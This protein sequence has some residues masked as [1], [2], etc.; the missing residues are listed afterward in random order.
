MPL[1]MSS[2]HRIPCNVDA[3]SCVGLEDGLHPNPQRKDSPYFIMCYKGFLTYTG[4]CPIDKHNLQLFPKNGKCRQNIKTLHCGSNPTAIVAH[5]KRCELYYNC[6][7]RHTNIPSYIK[8]YG[9]GP[10]HLKPYLHTCTYPFQFDSDLKICRN[11]TEVQCEH[12][13]V[14]KDA[15][16]YIYS[17]PLPMSSSHRIPCNVDAPSCVGL[18]DGLHPNPQKID[19]PYF[20]MCYKGYLTYTG[21]CPIDKHNLQLFPKNG[22]CRQNIKT[23]HC[24]S[25]PTAIV[26]HEKRCELYYNCSKRHTNIP[27]YIKNFGNG[28]DT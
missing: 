27:S 21:K 24:G 3:P 12:R 10:E 7:K 2:S 22:K 8:Y 26:A 25:N 1:P 28:P 6:S 14:E 5:E 4:K 17:L 19:S 20:I 11:F 18:E 16:R 15:C 9:N 23:L 13:R